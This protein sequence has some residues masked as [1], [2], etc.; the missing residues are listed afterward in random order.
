[1]VLWYGQGEE[2]M[3]MGIGPHLIDH[4]HAAEARR[5]HE[6]RVLVAY[7]PRGQDWPQRERRDGGVA[8]ELH[9]LA[10]CSQQLEQLIREL[11]LADALLAQKEQVLP[12]GPVDQQLMQQPHVAHDR[13]KAR[14]GHQRRRAPHA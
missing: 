3:G 6:S 13:N 4:Q 10:L 8:M 7:G 9:V 2:G 5:T 1:M 11:V 12:E 14:V